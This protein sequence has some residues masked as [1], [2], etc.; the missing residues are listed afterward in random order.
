VGVIFKS[1]LPGQLIETGAVATGY[2]NTGEIPAVGISYETGAFVERQLRK[3]PVTVRM[4]LKNEVLPNTIGWNVVGDISG[5]RYPERIV[6][7]GAHYDGHDIGQEAATDNI[8]GTLMMLDVARALAKFKGKFK[9][10]I[11]LVAFGND[12]CLS[13]GSVNYVAQHEKELQNI[14]VMISDGLGRTG[15]VVGIQVGS[16]SELIEPLS[17]VVEE[18]KID[19][20]LLGEDSHWGSIPAAPL[21]FVMAGVPNIGVG[22]EY[23]GVPTAFDKIHHTTADTFDKIDRVLIKQ[24]AVLLAELVMALADRDKPLARH[25]TREEVLQALT[26]S[27]YVDILKAQRRWHPDSVLGL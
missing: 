23:G 25:S 7:M 14:D 4:E 13:V 18:W 12:E 24:H 6:L 1:V 22:A 26:S 8:L 5:E 10:T 19:L 15:Q 9:R 21:P 2:R 27:G 20:P 17:K 16:P 3:G 11:R